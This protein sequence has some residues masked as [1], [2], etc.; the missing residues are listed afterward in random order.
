MRQHLRLA[1]TGVV[2]DHDAVVLGQVPPRQVSAGAYQLIRRG[3]S[4]SLQTSGN[5]RGLGSSIESTAVY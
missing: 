1:D 3:V 5:H 4:V 2:E